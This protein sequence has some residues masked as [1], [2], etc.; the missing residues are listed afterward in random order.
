[1]TSINKN[2]QVIRDLIELATYIAE[3]NLDASEIEETLQQ[4]L[5]QFFAMFNLSRDIQSLSSFK[6]NTS[7]F[8]EQMK[9]TRQPI[10][11]TVNGKAEIV[12]QDA[13]A[14]QKL[15]DKIEYLE[16]ITGIKEGLKD[17][18]AG[19]TYSLEEF[20]QEM[21]QKHGISSSDR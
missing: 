9:Q 12:V 21:Q 16:T 20:K 6:R 3:D 4:L 18:E 15:L 17:V 14:Y 1:M 19:Q 7:D 5:V 11:L 2:P 8:I 13:A 10:V